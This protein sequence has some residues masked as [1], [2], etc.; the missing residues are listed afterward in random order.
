VGSR[1][2]ETGV[3]ELQEFR[4]VKLLLGGGV[5]W[6]NTRPIAGAEATSAIALPSRYPPLCVLRCLLFT[7]FSFIL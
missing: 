1:Q 6:R 7:F 2:Q 5:A 3:Q 4:T